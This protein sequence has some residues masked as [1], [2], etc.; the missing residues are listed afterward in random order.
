MANPSNTQSD[1][2]DFLLNGQPF[3]T[4][5]AGSTAVPSSLDFIL[6]G[7]PFNVWPA[8]ASVVPFSGSVRQKARITSFI[9]G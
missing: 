9:W 6:N 5:P 8:D 2:F 1:S 4:R 3:V 7:Q